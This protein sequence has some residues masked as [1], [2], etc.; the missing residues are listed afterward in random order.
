[1]CQW[2]RHFELRRLQ[3]RPPR[4]LL[5]IEPVACQRVTDG[6][7]MHADLMR[8]PRFEIDGEERAGRCHG[9]RSNMR[10]GALPFITYTEFDRTDARNW[11]V[12][13]LFLRELAVTNRE[14]A[15]ADP[16]ALEQSREAHVQV[17]ALGEEDHATGTAIEPLHQIRGRGVPHHQ[18]MQE[19]LVGLMHPLLYDDASRFV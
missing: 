14:I 18:V 10:D 13:G 5:S 9:E 11:R 6:G 19:R 16:L 8:A 15:F 1:M 2:M 3:H 12:D 7:Q 17:A 4:A